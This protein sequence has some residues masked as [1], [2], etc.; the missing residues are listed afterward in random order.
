MLG[1]LDHSYGIRSSGRFRSAIML[2]L[3]HTHRMSTNHRRDFYQRVQINVVTSDGKVA[4]TSSQVRL[5]K[6]NLG[7]VHLSKHV[8]H[9]TLLSPYI[10]TVTGRLGSQVWEFKPPVMTMMVVRLNFTQSFR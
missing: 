9:H 2:Q 8:R 10:K 5:S 6:H 1:L 4:G 7:R 3:M